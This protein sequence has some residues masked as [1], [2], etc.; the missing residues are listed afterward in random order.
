MTGPNTKVG[1][2]VISS[3]PLFLLASQAAFSA[4]TCSAHAGV[5]ARQRENFTSFV[6]TTLDF[7]KRTV[8]DATELAKKYA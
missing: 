5:G 2:I 3:K 6:A 7:L 1:Q 8:A 4:A